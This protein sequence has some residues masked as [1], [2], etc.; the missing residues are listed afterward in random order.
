MANYWHDRYLQALSKVREAQSAHTR[1]AYQDL[2]THYKAMRQ[3]CERSP[4][5][6]EY[7][8]AA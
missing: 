2:A 8:S 4:I 6:D 1:R 7:K 5:G 3:F